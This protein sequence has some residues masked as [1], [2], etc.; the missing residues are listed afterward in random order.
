[1]SRIREI[2]EPKRDPRAE[3]EDASATPAPGAPKL[4]PPPP[5]RGLAPSASPAKFGAPR[6]PS[7]A[8]SPRPSAPLRPPT[9]SPGLRP[10]GA[11][12]PLARP[13]PP[14]P[15]AS[16]QAGLELELPPVPPAAAT[17]E[18][19]LDLGRRSSNPGA[20]RSSGVPAEG[21][22]S[23]PSAKLGDPFG[24]V[25]T[26]QAG[27]FQVEKVVAHGGFGVIY[28]AKHA[29][30]RAPVALKCLKIPESLTG[31][32][33]DQFLERFR[34]EGEVMFRL[35]TSIPEVVRPL[36]VDFMK[37]AKGAVVPFIA[38]E[39]LEGET[40]K[41]LIVRRLEAGKA[42]IRIERAVPYLTPVARALSRAHRFP[43]PD[44]QPL[45]IVHCDLKPDNVFV[46]R[47]D[48]GEAFKIF[49]FGIAKVRL[50]ASREAG[51]F[52]RAGSNMFTPA[53][54]APEQWAP[55]RFGQTGPWTDVY[56]FALT[57]A[58][59][60]TQ[61]PAIDGSPASMLRQALDEQN[62]P[63]P[64]RLG[65]DIPEAVDRVFEK[66]LAVSPKDRTQSIEA[67]WSAL[68][69]TLQLPQSLGGRHSIASMPAVSHGFEDDAP[70]RSAAR[71]PARP[72]AAASASHSF[73]EFELGELP[74]AAPPPSALDGASVSASPGA[75]PLAAP[76]PEPFPTHAEPPPAPLAPP[77]PTA[78]ALPAA[79]PA[80]PSTQTPPPD[81]TGVRGQLDSD[82]LG[83]GSLSLDIDRPAEPPVAPAGAAVTSGLPAF[84]PPP[85]SGT[86]PAGPP[87]GGGTAAAPGGGTLLYPPEA[88]PAEAP[89]APVSARLGAAAS[90][91]G[92]VASKAGVVAAGAAKNLAQKAL[93]VEQHQRIQLDKPET[94]LKPMLVPLI[95]MG[96]A[97]VITI[98]AIIANR[99]LEEQ[100]KVSWVSAPLIVI[101]VAF[102]VYRWIK[103]QEE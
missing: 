42:P 49:D 34:S 10:P 33:R 67:F 39:W 66:A 103:L 54:A 7:A 52:T 26:V 84:G 13:A 90:K 48:G 14:T 59:L 32:E 64:R 5:A 60:I 22:A 4:A 58:E 79:P 98:G 85:A 76:A 95:V 102:A 36:Q 11:A 75:A 20:A 65:L 40:L 17:G 3:E 9:A 91:A 19:E 73:G 74:G 96:A 24:I 31:A 81:V 50:A 89:S 56:A 46:V 99:F 25:G 62:R 57:L 83:S 30:F 53:Y 61:R 12:A 41:D 93:S 70:P 1:M 35:S 88:D 8:V 82:A 55:D 18:A 78:F 27:T 77:P 44:G 63:T 15:A 45:A 71:P 43:G 68:E 37:L 21:R 2:V 23:D 72:A 100:I 69:D 16:A 28:R 80:A 92:V 94:W 29:G 101:S 87:S 86:P 38:L 47:M 6:P 97:V 51:G